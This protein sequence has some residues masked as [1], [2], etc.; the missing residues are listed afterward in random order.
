MIKPGD[1]V[2]IIQLGDEYYGRTGK[3]LSVSRSLALVEFHDGTT[4]YYNNMN[5]I[6][7]KKEE[8]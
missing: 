2:Q 4:R 6:D 8:P 1:K 5:G 7:I 3:V